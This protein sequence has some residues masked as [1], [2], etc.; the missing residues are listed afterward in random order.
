MDETVTC[1]E[2]AAR[3]KTAAAV[4]AQSHLLSASSVASML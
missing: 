2:L 1:P 3:P 4:A